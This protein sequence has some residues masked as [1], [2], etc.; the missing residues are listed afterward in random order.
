MDKKRYLFVL[1]LLLI[2]IIFFNVCIFLE[3]QKVR[4][5][6][7]SCEKVNSTN[8]YCSYNCKFETMNE[9]KIK[10]RIIVTHSGWAAIVDKYIN[11]ESFS[12]K[13][14]KRDVVYIVRVVYKK[15]EEIYIGRY[16][17]NC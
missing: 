12:F 8:L 10:A 13:V 7:I 6:F 11:S 9:T 3:L 4:T 14:P 16:V 2:L 1:F 15:G 5:I 17:I